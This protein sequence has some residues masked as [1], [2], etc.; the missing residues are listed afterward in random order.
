MSCLETADTTAK[1][2][3]T[4]K[5]HFLLLH[6]DSV[7]GVKMVGLAELGRGKRAGIREWAGKEDETIRLE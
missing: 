5:R 2:K 6:V 1:E 4:G 3:S 7:R